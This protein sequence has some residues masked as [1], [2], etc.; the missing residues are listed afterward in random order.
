[1]IKTNI[2]PVFWYRGVLK[3]STSR[4]GGDFAPWWSD[5]HPR[6]FVLDYQH[7]WL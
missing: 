4:V 1:M 7:R 3:G 6:T 5:Q 2:C